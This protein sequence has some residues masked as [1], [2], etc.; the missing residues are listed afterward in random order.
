MRIVHPKKTIS[1]S[2]IVNRRQ[3]M[4][5]VLFRS[6]QEAK[7]REIWLKIIKRKSE[8]ANYGIKV[9]DNTPDESIDG[10]KKFSILY[11]LKY[12]YAAEKL[13]LE[14]IPVTVIEETEDLDMNVI[15][16]FF[17]SDYSSM[18]EYEKGVFL[19]KLRQDRSMTLSDLAKRAGYSYGTLQS[20]TSAFITSQ[21]YPCLEAAYK[22]GLLSS[23]L[24]R[25]TKKFFDRISYDH[26][27]LLTDYLIKNGRHAI[28][29]LKEAVN[30]R[31]DD[32]TIP[33]AILEEISSVETACQD[34]QEPGELERLTEALKKEGIN[35]SEKELLQLA[36]RTIADKNM[37]SQIKEC[38]K[39]QQKCF[40]FH[41]ELCAALP[42]VFALDYKTALTLPD[43]ARFSYAA[44]KKL[45]KNYK[46]SWNVNETRLFCRMLEY[47]GK[48]GNRFSQDA[49]IDQTYRLFLDFRCQN[50]FA[51]FFR[52]SILYRNKRDKLLGRL[53]M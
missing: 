3:A 8:Y 26:H 36:D 13:K 12:L 14:T 27:Q 39:I 1:L 2:Q 6:E 29:Q 32:T 23:Y 19:E 40:D 25:H 35:L 28:A 22:N 30:N 44:P 24:L 10:M 7:S 46:R 9:V 45:K 51:A 33:Q 42:P 52:F 31:K 50:S 18:T 49:L 48:S 21:E 16:A 4:K 41:K 53:N 17:N 11:G 37:V 20:L 43:H 34:I 47:L 38:L 15:T 5:R